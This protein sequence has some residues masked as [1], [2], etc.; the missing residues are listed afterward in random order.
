M[1]AWHI[2]LFL[3]FVTINIFSQTKAEL[4]NLRVEKLREIE[5]V[6]KTLERIKNDKNS[7]VNSITLLN[8][9]II[10]R[11]EII[12]GLNMEIDLIEQ[13]VLLLSD[14]INKKYSELERLKTEYSKIIHSLYY[15]FRSYNSFMFIIASESFNMAYRRFYYLKQYTAHRKKIVNSINEQIELIEGSISE[16]KTEK[17]NKIVL[18]SQREREN[19]LLNSDKNEFD[20]QV[21]DFS[22]KEAQ[23]RKELKVLQNA[24]KKIEKEIEKI[25]KEEAKAALKKSQAVRDLDVKL[26]KN[27]AD[28]KGKLPWPVASGNIVSYFGEHPHPVYKGIII[29][30][31]GIDISTGCKSVV[32]SVFSGEVSKIFAIKGANYAIIL[33]HGNYL[34]VYQNIT[35]VS[36]KMGQKI[37]VNDA[38]GKTF[39]SEG[40]NSATVHF[41][42]W[43]DLN[44]LNPVEW[45]RR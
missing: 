19:E 6:G 31:N 16:Y 7:A 12:Q 9:K 35:D 33:R 39:C 29:K 38:L 18:L 24:A 23:L 43:R 41:E 42:L 32:K 10:L 30:N 25:I 15:R 17:E 40:E 2:I 27:F 21:K 26:S 13:R 1:K 11:N 28:N 14:D 4:E 34:T 22:G 8:K 45:L 3:L 36:V 37:N 20:R 44:K 5:N